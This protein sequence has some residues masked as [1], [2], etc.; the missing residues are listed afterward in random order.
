VVELDGELWIG[1][2]RY[3]ETASVVRKQRA[4][5]GWKSVKL[6]V[7]DLPAHA[8]TFNQRLSEMQK[9]I[10]NSDSPYLD[11]VKQFKV[12]SHAELKQLLQQLVDEKNG[13]GIMLHR[14]T[15]LYRSGRSNDLL[16]FKLF[17]DAEAVVIGYRPG[18]GKYQIMTGS[19]QVR[20]RQGKE[21]FIGSGSTDAQR[22]HPPALG[23]QVTFKHQGLTKNGIPRFPVFLRVRDEVPE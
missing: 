19:L 14:G 3:E 4:H 21:F 2:G 17:D 15:A 7:F 13:E 22:L 9:S 23:T 18:T 10:A 16:K 8:G 6:M 11:T 5:S 1:R 20:D 12:K